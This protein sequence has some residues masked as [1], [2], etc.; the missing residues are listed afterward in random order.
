MF[1]NNHGP[2]RKRC[3]VTTH[4]AHTKREVFGQDRLVPVPSLGS[5]HSDWLINQSMPFFAV[6]FWLRWCATPLCY[7]W[8]NHVRADRTAAA[9]SSCSLD[10]AYKIFLQKQ[11]PLL[12]KIVV[13]VNFSLKK[14]TTYEPTGLLLLRSSCSSD[15][16]HNIFAK[17]NPVINRK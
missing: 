2:Y 6:S 4:H 1:D 14:Q 3:Q 13:I 15:C 7:S 11:A 8:N 5:P 9:A 16:A 17:T 12:T 10:C